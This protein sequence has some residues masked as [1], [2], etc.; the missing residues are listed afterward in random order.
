MAGFFLTSTL[1]MN[2]T[3]WG[4]QFKKKKWVWFS[5]IAIREGKKKP[6]TNTNTAQWALSWQTLKEL[7]GPNKS[8]VGRLVSDKVK[9][10]KRAQ[11]IMNKT[12]AGAD[13]QNLTYT[14]DFVD[15]W[16]VTGAFFPFLFCKWKDFYLPVIYVFKSLQRWGDG[17]GG[18]AV[19]RFVSRWQ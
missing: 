9:V 10:I 12:T 3:R 13:V 7:T 2:S 15:F 5:S 16:S 1:L 8:P 11:H 14:P 4:K 19:L 6:T 17:G 18:S